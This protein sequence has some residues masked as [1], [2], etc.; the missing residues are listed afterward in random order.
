MNIPTYVILSS[1]CLIETFEIR[2]GDTNVK[3]NPPAAGEAITD[4]FAC[5]T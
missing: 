2:I 1:C 4:N 5:H 3:E